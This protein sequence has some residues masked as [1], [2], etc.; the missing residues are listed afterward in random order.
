M[1]QPSSS[2]SSLVLTDFPP[3]LQL[4]G[5]KGKRS[6]EHH[7]IV[8]EARSGTARTAQPRYAAAVASV[9]TLKHGQV[10]PPCL[11]S[12][13]S[14]TR[15]ID[16]SS[17]SSPTPTRCWCQAARVRLPPT[18]WSV[19]MQMA[20]I[21][22]RASSWRQREAHTVASQT[23]ALVEWATTLNLEVPRDWIF[24]DDGY[25]GAPLERPGLERVR[26]L[27]AAGDIEV[28][29][30]Y[31][32]DRLS[33]KYAYQVLLIEEL[34]RHGVETRFLNAPSSGTADNQRQE[35]NALVEQTRV[36]DALAGVGRDARHRGT[37]TDR[38]APRQGGPRQ[39]RHARDSPL[40]SRSLG[41]AANGF[42][43]QRPS[44]RPRRPPKLPFAF[45]G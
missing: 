44:R 33:R 19:Y 38:A 36:S 1:R 39:R 42:R 4:G 32:P 15:S 40:Y 10:A 34:G 41:T 2:D 20:A 27:A 8:G 28:V 13:I 25:S 43:T 31:S 35:L 30:V 45:R 37:A 12:R 14:T 21:Y 17:A 26:N 5:V 18:E 9:K 24:E 22:T 7:T 23:A 3:R 29:L 11:H 6:Q 16:F